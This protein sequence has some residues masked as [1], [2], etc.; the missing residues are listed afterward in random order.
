MSAIGGPGG[1]VGGGYG[2][3]PI[4]RSPYS[5]TNPVKDAGSAGTTGAYTPDS[6]HTSLSGITNNPSAHQP[7]TYTEAS[8][9]QWLSSVFGRPPESL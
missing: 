6:V 3:V 8:T 2:G 5:S 9:H 4:S 7:S 1:P